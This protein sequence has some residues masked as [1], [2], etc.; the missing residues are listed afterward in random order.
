VLSKHWGLPSAWPVLKPLLFW[1]GNPADCPLNDEGLTVRIP[2]IDPS[3]EAVA[4][5][6]R[7]ENKVDEGKSKD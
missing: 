7:G 2:K 6:K 5:L 1:P 3:V 4:V